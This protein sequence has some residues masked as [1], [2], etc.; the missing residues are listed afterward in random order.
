MTRNN[1][2]RFYV[3]LEDGLTSMNG[4]TGVNG[5]TPSVLAGT[6]VL[7]STLVSGSGVPVVAPL[8]SGAGTY[9]NISLLRNALLA[10]G[11]SSAATAGVPVDFAAIPAGARLSGNEY[12]S[13]PPA[14]LSL[15]WGGASYATLS[16]FRAATGQEVGPGGV[17]TGSDADPGL[18]TAGGFFQTCVDWQP[19]YPPIPNSPT[20]DALRGFSGC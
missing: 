16:A 7:G 5:W 9:V 15:R 11:G 4:A 12:W 2:V 19:G 3:S 20:L 10:L 18:S 14:P 17:P 1:S 8:A 6:T 13:A